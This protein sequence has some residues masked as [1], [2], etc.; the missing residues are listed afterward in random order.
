MRN[1]LVLMAAVLMTGCAMQRAGETAINTDAL[2]NLARIYEAR[3]DIQRD[4]GSALSASDQKAFDRAFLACL[5]NIQERTK[6]VGISWFNKTALEGLTVGKRNDE[7]SA[8]FTL[9]KGNTETPPE[10][11][12][13][14]GEALGVGIAA[15]VRKTMMV[16]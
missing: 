12:K 4:S 15:G 16:P 10:T 6:Y 2:A 3:R 11:I 14:V 13:A 1:L 7:E 9:E 8:T 5:E